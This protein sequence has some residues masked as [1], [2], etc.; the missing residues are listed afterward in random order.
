M[1][2]SLRFAI[3]FLLALPLAA[4][5]SGSSGDGSPVAVSGTLVN[6]FNRPLQGGT[7]TFT[8]PAAARGEA[9]TFS[10]PDPVCTTTTGPNGSFTCDLPPGGYDVTV[11]VPGY[12]TD[13]FPIIVDENGNATLNLPGLTGDGNIDAQLV[14][15]VSGAILTFAHVECRR[16]L[17]D[18]T[19]TEFEFDATT[20]AQGMIHLEGVFLGQAECIVQAGASQ[21]PIILTITENTDG[22]IPVTPPP[23]PGAYRV[24]LRWGASPSDLDSH[25]TGP[26][27]TDANARFHIFYA[28][29]TY[30][31]N[32][33]D[34]D[35]TSSYGP[36][37]TTFYP[38][39]DGIY[40][41]TV[42]NYTQRGSTEG[43]QS[44][45]DSPTTV[46]LYTE[47]GLFRTYRAPLPTDA[48]FGL[49]ANSW[50]VFELTKAGSSI[51]VSGQASTP[52]DQGQPGLRYVLANSDEDLGVFRPGAP[53]P[54]LPGFPAK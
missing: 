45:Y 43:G 53:R 38:T 33:L 32:N 36:E 24:V 29:K 13:T 9:G 54:A 25:L 39:H 23:P 2:V 44:I 28:Q 48:N 41:F 11:E 7:L 51:T 15:A 21:I 46:E 16:Q 17:P 52:P 26:D 14:D 30:G 31:P 37:T 18:G 4:C 22:T 8:A 1:R 27:S 34:L 12:S 47:A 42:H 3:V 50:R 49:V 19:Y 35:D 5:D 40:R 6:S 10:R 20:D